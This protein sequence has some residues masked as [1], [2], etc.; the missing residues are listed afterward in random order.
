MS[1]NRGYAGLFASADKNQM[2]KDNL[3]VAEKLSN[4]T[5]NKRK[6]E[7]ENQAKVGLMQDEIKKQ[8][9]QLLGYDRKK[10]REI[11][12]GALNTLKNQIAANGGDY[13]RFMN[14][15]GRAI[16]DNYKSS[17]LNSDLYSNYQENQ[18]NMQ[19]IL[20]LEKKGMGHLINPVDRANMNAYQRNKG[21]KI[22]YTGQ[23]MQ[24]ELP[25]G[26][27]YDWN[28]N[29]PVKDILSY[30]DNY[31]KIME[32]YRMSFPGLK[33]PPS[34]E[35]L[36]TYVRSQYSVRGTDWQRGANERDF[37]ASEDQRK[38]GNNQWDA[39][40][41]EN[42]FK[43]RRDFSEDGRR[44]ELDRQDRLYT[45]EL[46]FQQKFNSAMNSQDGTISNGIDK[47]A[48]ESQVS[49]VGIINELIDDGNV[50][51]TDFRKP[52]FW[53]KVD[54]QLKERG[55]E[56]NYSKFNLSSNHY[57]NT[58]LGR[59]LAPANARFINNL[60]GS[61]AA[62][63]SLNGKFE[64]KGNKVL[65]VVT[66]DQNWFGADGRVISDKA[67]SIYKFFEG[68]KPR[69][70]T[71]KGVASVATFFDGKGNENIVMDKH[72]YLGGK[73]KTYEDDINTQ[74]K[75]TKVKMKQMVV[76]QADSGELVYM[77][78]N[79]NDAPTRQRY[80]DTTKSDNI[81]PQR[82][83]YKNTSNQ[84]TNYRDKEKKQAEADINTYTAFINDAPS[85][86]AIKKRSA[87]LGDPL[88]SSKR[89]PLLVAY[90]ATLASM[91]QDPSIYKTAVNGDSFEKLL[92]EAK[93]K[94]TN[95]YS[96]MKG[97][98][99]DQQIIRQLSKLDQNGQSDFY[100]NWIKNYQNLKNLK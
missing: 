4:F 17:I 32:N 91:G 68:S 94:N 33:Q 57:G 37:A 29:A 72:N 36:N 18:K 35:D 66:K 100:D 96:L 26:R 82:K 48:Q 13:S 83:A 20:E 70:L 67:S 15:G 8:T 63:A 56:M 92:S 51:I 87:I 45:A 31:T 76:L 64:V 47:D 6:E 80:S 24:V 16:L 75:N 59:K 78:F 19:T 27:N 43:D 46:N 69:D 84:I 12:T 74:V 95:G 41:K 77:P 97:N 11:Q 40:F 81:T 42:V 86:V 85:N 90:Y 79:T 73:N 54:G 88:N 71:I 62:S 22:S 3:V 21:G 89:A 44:Y 93:G 61:A 1:D 49:N 30:K 10:L 65:G 52:E 9:D 58:T 34:Q 23:M 99:D 2:A 60:D 98:L 38:I 7:E 50:S 14:N 25:D 39:T 28:T 53:N 5:D 55:S